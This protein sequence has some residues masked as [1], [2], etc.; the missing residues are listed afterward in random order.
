VGIGGWQKLLALYRQGLQCAIL[1]AP[2]PESDPSHAAY[3]DLSDL[4]VDL[5][6]AAVVT[7]SAVIVVD[8]ENDDYVSSEDA[9]AVSV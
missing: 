9:A 4:V 3:D 6:A 7:A 5:A 1:G 8:H 2:L